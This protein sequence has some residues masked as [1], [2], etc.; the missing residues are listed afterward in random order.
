MFVTKAFGEREKFQPEKIKR[1]CMRAGAS[2]KLA[3]EIAHTVQGRCYD[4]IS[5]TE[6][7]DMTLKLLQEK[8]PSVAAKY[9]LKRAIMQLG[10]SGFPFERLISGL[11]EEYGY[12]TK[13]DQIINGRCAEHEIDVVA[14]RDSAIYMI[15]CKYHNRP[16]IFT[17]LKAALCVQARFE[18]LIEGFKEGK[19]QEFHHPWLVCN[20]KF[21]QKA[22]DYALCRGI[23]ITGWNY[24]PGESISAMLTEKGVYPITVLKSLDNYAKTQLFEANLMFCR[25]LVERD[26]SKLKIPVK[27]L[28][29]IVKEAEGVVGRD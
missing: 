19:C 17:G 24:P 1:T 9:D 14:E 12:R 15:E 11:F 6:I 23:R 10:P 21:S 29:A 20:T 22:F 13:V 27:R 18:D 5:T 26:T 8:R 2:K 16:G 4:G 25:D 28:R 3:D 7:L